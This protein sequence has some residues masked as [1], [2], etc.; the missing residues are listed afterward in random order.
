LKFPAA[1]VKGEICC[2]LLCSTRDGEFLDWVTFSISRH[3]SLC[4]Y[5]LK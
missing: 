2:E 3:S 4:S 1:Q 5:K